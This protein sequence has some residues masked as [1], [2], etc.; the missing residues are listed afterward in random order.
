M[1]TS[2]TNRWRNSP[3]RIPVKDRAKKTRNSHA[4]DSARNSASS[5]EGKN[6]DL[7]G[8]FCPHSFDAHVGERIRRVGRHVPTARG[9]V[10]ERAT[11]LQDEEHALVLHQ[12]LG[13]AGGSV[14]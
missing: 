6:C 2:S 11:S 4:G 1:S 5:S 14:R 13:G 12:P 9:E 7:L 3:G 8:V 10:H